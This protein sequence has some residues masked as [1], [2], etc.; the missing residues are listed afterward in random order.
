M[1]DDDAHQTLPL[2]LGKLAGNLTYDPRAAG[3]LM[4]ASLLVSLPMVAIFLAFQRQ[5]VQG[6]TSGATKG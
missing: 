1:V 6:L 3:P 4:A 5:F 2:A